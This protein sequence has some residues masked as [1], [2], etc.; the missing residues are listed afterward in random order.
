MRSLVAAAALMGCIFGITITAQAQVGLSMNGNTIGALNPVPTWNPDLLGRPL[1]DSVPGQ[2][3]VPFSVNQIP[4]LPTAPPTLLNTPLMGS[5]I[6][7]GTH[8]VG[9]AP[10]Y[11]AVTSDKPALVVQQ[12]PNP[13]LQCPFVASV[14]QTASTTVITNPGGALLH[15]CLIKLVNSA[16]G[17]TQ[18][19]GLQEG[20]GTTCATN[21]IYI[22]GGS[23]GTNSVVAGGGWAIVNN[24][25]TTPMQRAGDNWCVTQTL[26]DNVSGYITYGIFAE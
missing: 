22:D 6:T 12:S 5:E 8:F 21:P 9:I 16:A 2:P 1:G 24:R 14:N 3:N 18:G 25:I 11:K 17:A 7:D 10:A 23:G 4:Q 20:T 15:I 26:T 19:I 13:S